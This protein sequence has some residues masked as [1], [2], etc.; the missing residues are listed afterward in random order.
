MKV[1]I[2]QSRGDG[3]VLTIGEFT[4]KVDSRFI[5]DC[6]YKNDDDIDGEE[7]EALKGAASSR[8]AFLGAMRLLGV[9]DYGSRELVRK[10]REK[11]HRAEYA[12]EAVR[13]AEKMG[14]IDD[15]S[16]A[17]SL[18][19]RLFESKNW[20]LGRVRSELISRGISAEIADIAV[21]NI[22]NEPVLRIIDIL[23]KKFS[24]KL[25]DEKGAA[26][27]V[28]RLRSLGYG[29]ADISAALDE[30]RRRDE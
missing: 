9:R 26:R 7:L 18:A 13:K 16:Y 5:E 20:S 28:N 4:A 25:E 24:G 8:A 1:E 21:E 27:A 23:D 29:W 22:D 3:R 2:K 12:S 6:G 11:G 15:E 17:I 14:L 19:R 30:V 10:L